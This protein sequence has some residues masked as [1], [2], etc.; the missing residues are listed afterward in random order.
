MSSYSGEESEG[1][2][3][4]EY[5]ESTHALLRTLDSIQSTGK[6]TTFNLYTE[7]ANPGLTIEGD[8]LISLPLKE[9]DAQAIKSICQQA[10]FGHGNKT[11]VD[12]SVRN[13]WE[14]DA[15]KFNLVN[16]GWT[17]YFCSRLLRDT[18]RELGFNLEAEPHKL[19]LYEPGSFF[20][21]HKDSEKKKGMIGTLVV[22]LPSQHE[23][24]DVCLSFGSQ[25]ECLS[26]AQNSKFD[27]TTMSWYSD[28]THEVKELTSGYR[29]VLTYKLFATEK[30]EP[31]ASTIL[32][33][34]Q[35]LKSMLTRF[36]TDFPQVHR[37]LYPLDH[38]YTQSSLCL[39]N[40]K[41]RDR[42]VGRCLNEICSQA[43]FYFMMGH[44]THYKAERN[45]RYDDDD[46]DS[47][48][49]KTL[50]N[51]NGD[52]VSSDL[53]L[54]LEDFL[55]YDIEREHPDSEDEGG[56]TGNEEAPLVFHY[57]KTVAYLVPKMYLFGLCSNKLA[58]TESRT[59]T[60]D[61][62]LTEMVHQ[63]LLESRDDPYT[64]QVATTFIETVLGAARRPWLQRGGIP[65]P[66]SKCALELENMQI[67]QKCLRR[68]FQ[69]YGKD[70]SQALVGHLRK[71]CD[72]KEQVIDWNHWLQH[73]AHGDVPAEA[74]DEFCVAFK[75]STTHS[76]LLES[77]QAWKDPIFEEK[78]QSQ[79]SW[80]HN[81]RGF[82]LNLLKLRS[83]D[84]EWIK[85]TF[86]QKIV[87]KAE[88]SLLLCLLR[89]ISSE[90]TGSFK[91]SSE[92]YNSTLEC[93]GK[94]LC[95][96]VEELKSHSFWVGWS[97][98]MELTELLKEAYLNC[99]GQEALR[100]LELNCKTFN[101]NKEVWLPDHN[102]GIYNNFLVPLLKILEANKVPPLPAVQ[103]FWEIS[104]REVLHRPIDSRPDELAGW[105]HKKSPCSEKTEC[106]D[107]QG[108]NAFLEDPEQQE[109]ESLIDRTRLNHLEYRLRDPIYSLK[110]VEVDSKYKLTVTK[111]G[112]N[113]DKELRGW[114]E[115]F[116]AV[117][118]QLR[119]LR[120]DYMRSFLG[121]EKY[122]ELVLLEKPGQEDLRQTLASK[123]PSDDDDDALPCAKRSRPE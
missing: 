113:F 87:P 44:T 12:T 13:T 30:N 68:D 121:D 112:T 31:S 23:G 111:R 80:K 97:V 102:Y 118:S 122:K 32:Q 74:F 27:L 69:G 110:K 107:C 62:F 56:Y 25:K 28:V 108:L 92:L 21:P 71:H 73:L 37:L 50:Y 16:K 14:L 88:K 66:I 6:I 104:L 83:G 59:G 64:R 115:G 36:R 3:V 33:Q 46:E 72:G 101:K 45:D 4:N 123:R 119:G 41:G 9:D 55:G 90:R 11:I 117:E 95:P 84:E 76:P 109:W 106:E 65:G 54:N 114:Q 49:L 24:G 120:G 86:L 10:P 57:H 58:W 39:K 70:I 82:I 81:H 19:L 2:S 63:D 8:R 103:D 20:K 94:Q 78:I 85:Q 75:S 7:Y 89:E 52:Q 1:S 5:A 61:H 40:L 47:T 105:A 93:A 91:K 35:H 116:R 26:T 43:G 34:T 79:S 29:L 98:C 99:A 48:S 60:E 42:A 15:S 38:L 18:A 53:I 17:Q 51:L 22:C 77:F 67:F 96:S 100:V